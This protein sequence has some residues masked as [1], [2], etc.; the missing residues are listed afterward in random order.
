LD[1]CPKEIIQCTSADITCQW[2]GKREEFDLHLKTCPL[3]QIRPTI[4]QLIEQIK[5][6]RET[7]CEQQRFIQSFINNGFTLSHI[8][9]IIPCYFNRPHMKNQPP[10]MP[11]TLCNKQTHFT[12]TALHSCVTLTSICKSCLNEYNQQ[13]PRLTLKRKLS[14]SEQSNDGNNEQV[15]S[16]PPPWYES[17]HHFKYDSFV[18][19]HKQ[20]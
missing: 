12:E 17:F 2:I 1:I 6:I 13:T 14:L 3:Q 11:C 10:L 18:R 9:P 15:S 7:Q 5:T 19:F 20:F 4:D 16:S 8:C